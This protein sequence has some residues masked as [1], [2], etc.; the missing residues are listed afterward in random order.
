MIPVGDPQGGLTGVVGQ[1]CRVDAAV[2][3]QHGPHGRMVLPV[4]R[5]V[6]RGEEGRALP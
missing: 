1:A 2:C 6:Q 5:W 3:L 4:G